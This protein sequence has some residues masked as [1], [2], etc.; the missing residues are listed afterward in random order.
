MNIRF[1]LAFASDMLFSPRRARVYNSM[2]GEK[3]EVC[4]FK[5]WSQVAQVGL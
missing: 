5:T 1:H 3:V 2:V 4:M